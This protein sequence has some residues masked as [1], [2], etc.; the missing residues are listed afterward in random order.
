LI[1]LFALPA[2]CV[3]RQQYGGNVKVAA[4]L[5]EDVTSLTLP[6]SG[7]PYHADGQTL[8]IDFQNLNPDTATD[9]EKTFLAIQDS[10]NACHWIQDYPYLDHTHS[11][12]IQQDETRIIS[13]HSDD[14][15]TIETL[16]NSS[17]LLGNKLDALHP[18]ERTQ[19]GYEANTDCLAGRPFL[20]SIS[21]VVVDP[22]NPYLSF[23]LG[24]VDVISVPE[25]RFAQASADP[26]CTLIYGPKYV[27]YLRMEGF[28]PEQLSQL[29]N[30]I[31][32]KELSRAVLNDHVEILMASSSNNG[33]QQKIQAVF[34]N[35][36][37]GPYR[38]LGDR[39]KLQLEESGFEFSEKSAQR[40]I[41]LLAQPVH[42]NFDLTAYQ[43]IRSNFPDQ[44]NGVW[45]DSWDRLRSS[46]KLLPLLIHTTRVAVRTKIIDLKT[47]ADGRLN[48]ADCWIKQMP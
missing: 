11:T 25:D 21:P 22:V 10:N 23:K 17:C 36:P 43:I 34:Q 2:L 46:G 47:R 37:D 1:L 33:Q 35:V 8:T 7:I 29:M 19:Y 3:L 24:D 12:S 4:D 31:N 41:R 18:F 42:G 45:K 30:A 20:D 6:E 39:L 9:I 44:T 15:A 32:L 16:L 27:L 28:S 40:S 13:I 14:P 38:L 5:L 26:Q 48:F